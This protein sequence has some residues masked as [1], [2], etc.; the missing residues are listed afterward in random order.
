MAEK[1]GLDRA[2]AAPLP[3]RRRGRPARGPAR[4]R[5][6]AVPGARS[7]PHGASRAQP[8]PLACRAEGRGV[9][10]QGPGRKPRDDPRRARALVPQARPRGDRA[11]ARRRHR[12]RRHPLHAPHDPRPAHPLGQLLGRRVD[13]LQLAAAARPAGDRSTTW[14]STRSRTSTSWAT[15]AA[16]GALVERRCPAYRDH[17]RWLRRYGSALH[18]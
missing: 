1:R 16:S 18:L 11:P 12:A 5:L 7:G 17:E 15:R 2:H 6:G 14:S 4:R 9:G 13:E 10:R 8:R 3:D